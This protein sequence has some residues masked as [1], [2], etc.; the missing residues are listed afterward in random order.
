M[1]SNREECRDVFLAQLRSFQD[2][3]SMIDD[4]VIEIY[5]ENLRRTIYSLL[6][7]LDMR[8]MVWFA[9]FFCDMLIQIGISTAQE[10]DD[11]ILANRGAKD[12]TKIQKVSELSERVLIKETSITRDES[13]EMATDIT[14][15]PLKKRTLFHSILLTRSFCSCIIICASLRSAQLHQRFSS[16]SATNNS[17]KLN[18]SSATASV[19]NNKTPQQFFTTSQKF[20]FL[21]IRMCDSYQF[22]LQV[23]RRLC[24][25]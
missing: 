25:E 15:T 23:S 21:F 22:N 5:N 4:G 13:C 17:K 19:L 14:A 9:E 7:I 6:S 18:A 24:G 20:F 11:E 1:Y 16:T 3:K 12:Q 10:T 2:L 8:N